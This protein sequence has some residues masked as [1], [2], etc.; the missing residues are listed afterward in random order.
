M[1]ITMADIAA[2]LSISQ[3]TVSRVLNGKDNG[4]VSKDK[5]AKIKDAAQRLG[6]QTNMAAV[7]LRK[8]KTYTIGILLPSPRDSFVGEVV[9]DLQHLISNTRYI[10][11]FAFW[12][13]MEEAEKSACNILS[14]QVDAI[15]T[16]EPR[17]IPDNLDIPVIAYGSRDC[18]FD[19]VGYDYEQSMRLRIGYLTALGHRE[20]AYL[21]EFQETARH[22]VF[23][24]ILKEHN[25][26]YRNRHLQPLGNYFE[27]DWP[28]KLVDNFDR[29]WDSPTRP[30]AIIARNDA[31]AILLLH[32]AWE[33]GISIPAELSIIG[34]DNIPQS[35]HCIPPLTTVDKYNGMSV[36]KKIFEYLFSRLDNIDLPLRD[37]N[38]QGKLIERESCAAPAIT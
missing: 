14:R 2:R 26:N 29:L 19:Y 34:I 4:R 7:G 1:A 25:L 31:S 8:R 22:G 17:F 20:I 21:G 9:A 28:E 33:R 36:A 18:R 30:T 37:C 5:A 32:R 35:A 38:A 24:K 16:C 27:P 13:S 15:I 11:T 23:R 3:S 12:E 6:Y 10:A